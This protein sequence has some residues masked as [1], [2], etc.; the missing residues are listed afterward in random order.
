MT[1]NLPLVLLAF[2]GGAMLPVQIGVNGLLRAGLGHAMQATFVS[3][4]VGAIGAFLA[5]TVP[6]KLSK[7]GTSAK[8][9]RLPACYV[10]LLQS[11]SSMSAP[12][13]ELASLLREFC[14]TLT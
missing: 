5:R 2:L 8:L 3:F 11:P 1:S 6:E 12:A 13:R 4:A 10:N 9:P 7:L 14:A